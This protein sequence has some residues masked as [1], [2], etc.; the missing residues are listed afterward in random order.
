[1]IVQGINQKSFN[2]AMTIALA[3]RLEP[4]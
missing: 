4:G 3:M 1:L 2:I